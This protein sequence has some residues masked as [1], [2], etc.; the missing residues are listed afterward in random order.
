MDKLYIN[1][2]EYR[3]QRGWSQDELAARVGYTDRTSIAKI[4]SGQVNLAQSKVVKF[5][6][7]FGVSPSVL[8]GWDNEGSQPQASMGA[9]IKELRTAAGLTQEELGAKLGLQKSVIAKYENGRVENLK[10]ATITKLLQ[11]FGCSPSYLM[12]L[13]DEPRVSTDEG[14][15]GVGAKL[16][17]LLEERCLTVAELSRQ[18]GVPQTTIYSV[19]R[20]NSRR[21]DLNALIAIS[22]CLGVAPEYFGD[23]K[24]D[25]YEPDGAAMTIGQR[26]KKCRE[27]LGLSQAEL[28]HQ[29]GYQSR[30]SINKIELDQY[31]LPQS[32][33]KSLAEALGVSPSYIMGWEDEV[34]LQQPEA[35]PSASSYQ[36]A[37]QEAMRMLLQLDRD[38]LLIMQGE[39]RA[40]LRADKYQRV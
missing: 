12:G 23:G 29:V 2:K 8:T 31:G 1:I 20:R 32:K 21:T 7:V 15:A 39:L 18:S 36:L 5:A 6:K 14:G 25:S 27:Q 17:R 13:D 16:E 28:A 37:A 35:G 26:I 9:R 4:E 24:A 19:I 40:M 34:E 11:I 38:D 22:K 33:I 3:L 30:S 10:R